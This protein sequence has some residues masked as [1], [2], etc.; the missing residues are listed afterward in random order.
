MEVAGDHVHS[1]FQ[2]Q[3]RIG[4]KEPVHHPLGIVVEDNQ[5]EV[6]LMAKAKAAGR[7]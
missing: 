3:G 7:A 5:A 6:R 2:P 1:P 4:G